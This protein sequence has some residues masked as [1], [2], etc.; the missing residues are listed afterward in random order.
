MCSENNRNTC[1]QPGALGGGGWQVGEGSLWEEVRE[2]S[3]VC[4]D[5]AGYLRSQ[6]IQMLGSGEDWIGGEDGASLLERGLGA[7]CE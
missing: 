6:W 2:A 4:E 1:G 5:P 7:P 3:W